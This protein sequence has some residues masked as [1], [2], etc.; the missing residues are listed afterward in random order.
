MSV[1]STNFIAKMKKN[2]HILLIVNP[3]SGNTNKKR[4]IEMLESQ[5]SGIPVKKYETTGKKD[6]KKV[7]RLIKKYRPKRILVVGGD[8]TIKLVAEN[9][10]HHSAILGII[11]AGSAN[12]LARDLDI[13]TSPKRYVPIAL[14]NK[15]REIDAISI[16]DQFCLHIS[17]FGLNAELIKKYEES[18]SRG[19]FGYF[20][21]SISTLYDTNMPYDFKVKANGK[22]KQGQG[23]MLAIAN[24]RKY[25]T[26][27]VINPNGV[28]DDGK[29]EILIF[30]KFDFLQF[31][32]S[33]KGE[34]EIPSRFVE[35]IVTD[36]ATITTKT[37]VDFQ[38]DGEYR[39][40]IKKVKAKILPRRLRIAVGE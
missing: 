8:G 23:M 6:G 11:P 34:S 35:T 19:K 39:K 1:Q 24:S 12:G 9:L 2:G 27:V 15:T 4:I 28:I 14:G 17:D 25:G 37:P 40:A 20:I 18:N 21:N 29:F 32:N 13:P 30:K 5:L 26:G 16:N 3:I 31:L 7:R 10:K 36:K 22:V 33:L 38:I